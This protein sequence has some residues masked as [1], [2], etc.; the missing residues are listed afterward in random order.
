VA[1][2]VVARAD[3]V[4][5]RAAVV[6]DHP[7]PT[8]S[9]PLPMPAAARRTDQAHP[10]PMVI[11][12]L[13]APVYHILL[14]RDLRPEGLRRTPCLSRP[15][16]SFLACGSTAASMRTLTAMD[17]TGTTMGATARAMLLVCA[18]SIKSAGVIHKTT[19]RS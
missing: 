18:N 9:L 2:A 11:S 16:H 5:D 15:S 14:V 19:A 10:S 4:Q 6:H 8:P 3:R 17:T 1:V 12:T 7:H 13:A